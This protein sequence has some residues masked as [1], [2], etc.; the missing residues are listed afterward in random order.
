LIGD[1]VR[2]LLRRSVLVGGDDGDQF[3]RRNVGPVGANSRDFRALGRGALDKKRIAEST[4][5]GVTVA[6]AFDVQNDPVR[7][8]K[9]ISTFFL[10]N[11]LIPF[12]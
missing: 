9:G 8:I 11:V 5:A 7:R 1:L 3:I 10:E 4:L 12:F 2:L 6:Q